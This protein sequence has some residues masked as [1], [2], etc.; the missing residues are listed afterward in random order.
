[1]NTIDALTAWLDERTRDRA[2]FTG[3][4][5]SVVG[6]EDRFDIAGGLDALDRPVTVGSLVPGRCTVTKPLVALALCRLH[7]DGQ[8]DL[9]TDT[10]SG[11]GLDAAPHV[12]RLT[13][14]QLLGHSGGLHLTP[15]AAY[16][17]VRPEA[18]LALALHMPCPDGWDP[19]TNRAYDE[20]AA[21]LILGRILELATDAPY[22]D[23]VAV[24]LADLGVDDGRI[25]LRP[26]SDAT[27]ESWLADVAVDGAPR[28]DRSMRP[29][30]VAGIRQHACEWCPSW[31][32]F[33]SAGA[34][35]ELGHAL[36]RHR[37]T[38]DSLGAAIRLMA[39]RYRVD[40]ATGHAHG[41]GVNVD[42]GRWL[43][44]DALGTDAFGHVARAA[45][46]ASTATHG[47][48]VGLVGTPENVALREETW[49]RTIELALDPSGSDLN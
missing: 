7:V 41:L 40:P 28:R 23:A 13:L 18:R 31:S 47:I 32:G 46:F 10:V 36:A 25:L 37:G 11:F 29:M 19:A 5:V 30:M 15:A 16:S 21:W 2:A 44:S 3:Y 17:L 33:A 42:L 38:A 8:L 48:A 20:A 6:A 9:H 49:R 34:L 35:A 4:Q 22:D 45:M 12:G 26:G 39:S 43:T 1:M 14:A 24:A 27:D